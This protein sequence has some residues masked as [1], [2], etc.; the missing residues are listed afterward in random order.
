MKNIK[1]KSFKLFYQLFYTL[2][3]GRKENNH[4]TFWLILPCPPSALVNKTEWWTYPRH[5]STFSF[6][7]FLHM[8]RGISI[9]WISLFSLSRLKFLH[10]NITKDSNTSS[11]NTGYL[12]YTLLYS[13]TLF[14]IFIF[15]CSVLSVK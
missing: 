11:I 14:L 8:N 7:F 3:R 1:T 12:H 2:S 10:C 13:I 15:F 6:V 4:A 9:Q 5:W